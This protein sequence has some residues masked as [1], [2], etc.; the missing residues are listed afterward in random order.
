M[1]LRA[2][3][4][5][6]LWRMGQRSQLPRHQAALAE[7]LAEQA[8]GRPV[9]VFPPGLDW[10]QQLFQRPQQLALALA[11][12]GACVFYMEPPEAASAA[13]FRPA[14][15]RLYLAHVPVAAFQ[16]LAAPIVHV[17]TWNQKAA[18]DFNQ[19]RLLYDV[20][21]DLSAFSGPPARLARQHAWLLHNAR[22]VLTTARRLQAAVQ[23]ARPDAQLCPN[24][25]NYAHFA[26]AR[27]SGA[28]PPPPALAPALAR[29]RPLIGYHGAL[30]HW[31]DA[32]LLQAVAA[33]RPDLT[34]V[35]IGPI[36]AHASSFEAPSKLL[37]LKN[38]F[39]LD[40]QPYTQIPAYLR[41]F[42][43]AMIPFQVNALTQAT[44]PLKLFEYLASHKPIVC[45]PLEECLPYAGVL[46]AADP[47]A[48]SAQLDRALALRAD[49]A[50]LAQ[51]DQAAQA[52]TWAARSAQIM[53]LISAGPA[54]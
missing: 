50:Y 37:S 24:G 7:I 21:D 9:I 29:R 30:A 32:G 28:T 12:A 27:G 38:V 34:F 2:S 42:D 31:F 13:G 3:L 16:H 46:P 26:A 14:A 15:G 19:A 25:V 23:P 53:A 36:L 52:N 1:S 41:Y 6:R 45:T 48:F 54:R 8:G 40:T 10:Q 47:A 44:S 20:V 33:Q 11:Q 35:L 5:A 49:P 17:M 39:W 18:L 4:R 43:V 51:L 22:W